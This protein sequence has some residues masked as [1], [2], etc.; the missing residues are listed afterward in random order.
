[1]STAAKQVTQ[2]LCA[3]PVFGIK[4]QFVLDDLCDRASYRFTL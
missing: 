1:M 2:L 4:S 3:T